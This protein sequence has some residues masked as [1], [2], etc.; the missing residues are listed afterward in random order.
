MIECVYVET[1][2]HAVFSLTSQINQ[3]IIYDHVI[4]NRLAVWVVIYFA[5]MLLQ[6]NKY[7]A[8]GEES[9]CSNT[10]GWFENCYSKLP[11]CVLAEFIKMYKK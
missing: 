6:F 4:F 3:T 7:F 8:C 9:G 5:W 1:L 2:S 10:E 11:F